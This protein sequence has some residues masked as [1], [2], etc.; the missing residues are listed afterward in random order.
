MRELFHRLISSPSLLLSICVASLF[1]NL[2]ALASPLF[3]IQVLNRFVTQGVN[4]TLLTLTTGVLLS[5]LFELI[6]RQIRLKLA[7]AISAKSNIQ[8]SIAS[9][10]ILLKA[11]A[12][13][14]QRVP[15]G[16]RRQVITS[17]EKVI[18]AYGAG[19]IAL[20]FDVP[21][22][23]LFIGVLYLLSPVLAGITCFFIVLVYIIG[24]YGARFHQANSRKQMRENAETNMLVNT[25]CTQIDTVRAF[26]TFR[27]LSTAWIDLQF[28]TTKLRRSVETSQG[29]TSSLSQSASALLSV[30]I[31][32][33]G[34][35]RV[36]DGN[37]DVGS[38]IGANILAA[39][40]LMPIIRLSQL[41]VIFAG[42]AEGLRQLSEFSTIPQEGNGTSS[43]INY[44]GNIEFKDV[45]FVYPGST[46]PIFESLSFSIEP[47]SITAI[48][49]G[50]GVGKSTLARMLAG[51]I[52][53]SRGQMLVDGLD[54]QQASLEWW[55]MQIAYLPQEPS[56]LNA[57]IRENIIMTTAQVDELRLAK[58][59]ES[60]GLVK[61]LDE[62]A[63]GLEAKLTNNGANLSLGIRHR[64]SLA[65]AL[66]S[67]CKIAIFD[68]PTDG[69]DRYGIS[70]VYSV[71]N[72][73]SSQGCAIIIIS[74]DPK[75]IKNASQV[76]DLSN[77]PIPRV[78]KRA[79]KATETTLTKN[80]VP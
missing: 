51:I 73:L 64:I 12:T 50:N 31:I 9:Y 54:L 16:L 76:I 38:M 8:I 41:G 68:E 63:N 24:W 35:M 80:E 21:F 75:I 71:L 49:G 70:C 46:T 78:T 58:I 1:I 77:K 5:I 17:T 25:A 14:L 79:H 30:T 43:K 40:A 65:R 15:D 62:S 7:G 37:L 27:F 61:Y 74:H 28:R 48:F 20:V 10:D 60:V 33:I 34:A 11:K 42:A 32:S 39:R 18:D 55:R 72:N 3:V 29:I 4:A 47:Q 44:I 13:A 2:L 23:L 66:M 53:P 26:N 67:N 19:N 57:T 52:H 56:F 45:S 59:I 36:V 22:S 6:F 69:L